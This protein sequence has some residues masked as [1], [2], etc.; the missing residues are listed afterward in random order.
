MAFT[1]ALYYPRIEIRDDSWLKTA[2]LYWDEITTIV[3]ASIPRPYSSSVGQ[4]LFEARVLTPLFVHPGLPTVERLA[5]KVMD[6]LTSPETEQVLREGGVQLD[7]FTLM[8]PEKLPEI[9]RFIHMHPEKLPDA[10]RDRI[11]GLI[12]GS[13]SDWLRV[14]PAFANYY[15][16]LLASEL[17]RDAGAG[18]MTDLP[19]SDRLAS[20][21]RRDCSPLG[22]SALRDTE[23]YWRR[24][25]R[26]RFR[27]NVPNQ[28]AQALLADLTLSRV[29]ISGET[30]IPDLLKFRDDHKPQLGRLRTKLGDLTKA[31]DCDLSIEAL[32]QKVADI[33]SNDVAPAI[34]EFKELLSASRIKWAVESFL[35]TSFLSVPTGSILL[36]AGLG[37]PHALLASAGVSLTASAVLLNHERQQEIRRNPFSYVLAAESEFAPRTARSGL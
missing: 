27:R 28:I 3:P 21:A 17:A 5:E 22:L 1:K 33:Y 20:V 25:D 11:K 24:Y 19:S 32:Q 10:I 2:I 15:M 34:T 30:R 29:S 36:N 31:V 37:I 18:L 16:T 9:G 35:K 14:H 26:H 12:E 8:H 23:P 6:Y 13:D 7:E 4:E